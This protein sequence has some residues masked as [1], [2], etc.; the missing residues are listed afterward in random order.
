MSLVH[1][2]QYAPQPPPSA[3]MVI[4]TT[5]R[6]KRAMNVPYSLPVWIRNLRAMLDILQR[7]R[8]VSNVHLDSINHIM[9]MVSVSSAQATPFVLPLILNAQ[10][11]LN[12][13]K[14]RPDVQNVLREWRNRRLEISDVLLR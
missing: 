4:T 11:I 12:Q 7:N 6:H 13:I 14:M 2:M 1:E 3:R 10:L 8:N 9:E 5:K